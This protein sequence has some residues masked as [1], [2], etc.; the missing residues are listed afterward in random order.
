MFFIVS[1]DQFLCPLDKVI[2][3]FCIFA[4]D[5]SQLGHIWVSVLQNRMYDVDC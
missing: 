2:E 5:E 4:Y 3:Q 1:C